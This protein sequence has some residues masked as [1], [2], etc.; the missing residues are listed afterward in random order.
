MLSVILGAILGTAAS[1]AIAHF[2]YSRSTRDLKAEV[3]GL[4]EPLATLRSLTQDLQA[5]VEAIQADTHLTKKHAVA[6]T[7]DDPEFPYK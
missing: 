7:P 3:D 2:Y 1:L 6:N 4:R 5:A